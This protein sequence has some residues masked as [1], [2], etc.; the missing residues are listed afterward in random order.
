MTDSLEKTLI[1]SAVILAGTLAASAQVTP[2]NPPSTEAAPEQQPSPPTPRRQHPPQPQEGQESDLSRSQGV[3]TPP[4]TG[5]PVVKTPDRSVV[6]STPVIPP[7][8]T[9]GGRQDIEPK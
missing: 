9:P 8:G 3:L 4:Q 1:A 5:D 6:P 2:P 7:P